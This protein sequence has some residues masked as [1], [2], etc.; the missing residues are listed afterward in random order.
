M[1]QLKSLILDATKVAMKARDKPRVAALRLVQADIK[2]VEVDERKALSDQEVIAVLT[3]M[4]KQRK[5]SLSQF[6]SAGR[7]DLADQEQFEIDVITEFMPA[8]LSEAE[9]DGLIEAAI[10]ATGA[11]SMRDMGKVMAKLKADAQGRT[12]MAALSAKVRAKL[13]S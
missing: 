12:D 8:A 1:S 11:G 5:D 10:A 4:L 2:R 6:Q 9:V 3:R 7:R 13:T